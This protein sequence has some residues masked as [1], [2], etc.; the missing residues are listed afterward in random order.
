MYYY[1]VHQCS[2]CGHWIRVPGKLSNFFSLTARCPS[3]GTPQIKALRRRDYIDRMYHNPIS[4]C[5]RLLG[6]PLLHCESCRLQFY[7]IRK[8][9]VPRCKAVEGQASREPGSQ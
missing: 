8:V 9:L 3:C 7:D 6:A 5:Q 4:W 2:D 1:E